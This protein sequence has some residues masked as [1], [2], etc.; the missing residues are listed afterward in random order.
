MGG[1]AS[2]PPSATKIRFG[3]RKNR[4]GG[5]IMASTEAQAYMGVWGLAFSGV[6][7]QSPWS[8]G[9]SPPVADAFL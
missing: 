1:I 7:G 8:G 5:R 6:Q 3:H 9:R 2:W 4:G